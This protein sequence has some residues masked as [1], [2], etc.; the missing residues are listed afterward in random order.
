MPYNVAA[1][2]SSGYNYSSGR[3][4]HQVYFRMLEIDRSQTEIVALDDLFASWRD[5]AILIEG[6]LPQSLRT[7]ET[8]WAHTWFWDGGDLL[9]P[10]GE[11]KAE[12]N[13][14]ESCTTTLADRWAKKGRDWRVAMR[15]RAREIDLQRELG[16]PL[17]A[18]HGTP[19]VQEDGGGAPTPAT[20]AKA[21]A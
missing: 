11:S 10:E 2:N 3:L 19:A 16:I 8:D 1:G 21:A 9:D 7:N 5:E 20:P 18:N 12:A 15:Q 4:D 6:Y 17:P 13:Q 14:L